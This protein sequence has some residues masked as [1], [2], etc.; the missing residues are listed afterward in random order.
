MNQHR[1][2]SP[3]L[4]WSSSHWIEAGA[5]T[6][7]SLAASAEET[8][9]VTRRARM[10]DRNPGSNVAGTTPSNVRDSESFGFRSIHEKAP[11]TSLVAGAG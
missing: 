6:H 5:I 11:T 7:Y 10:Q 1:A 9:A 4:L 3:F 2:K 8:G